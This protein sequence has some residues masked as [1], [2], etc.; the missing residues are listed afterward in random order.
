[1]ISP[2]EELRQ[3]RIGLVHAFAAGKNGS[4]FLDSHTETMDHYFRRSLQE[5][6]TGRILF[7]EK[8]PLAVVALGGYGRKELCLHSDIDVMILF[9]SKIPPQAKALTDE[10]L[11]P[12]WDIGLDLGYS[13]R[14]AKDCLRLGAEDFEVLTSLMD[15]RFL[16]G[17]SPLYLSL[18]KDLSAK[19]IRK[20][21][22]IFGRW[23]LERDAIRMETYGDASYLLEPDLKE[24]IG[25]LRDYHHILWLA[26]AFHKLL[27][28]RDLEYSGTLSHDEYRE[29]MG[30]LDFIWLVRN[31]LHHLSGRANDRLNF[32]YQERIADKLGFRDE[33]H[34]L[35]VEHF[36]GRLHASMAFI[37]SLHRSFN[38]S[39]LSTTGTARDPGP[40]ELTA[41]LVLS[42]GETHFQSATAIPSEPYILMEVFRRSADAGLSLS[43]DAKRLV[44][45]FL[46]LVDDTFRCAHR[47]IADFLEII[48][49]DHACEALDQMDETGFL[50]AFIPEIGKVRD[51]VQFDA[52]HIYPVGRHMIQTLRY[53]K[54][55]RKEKNLIL[56]DVFS[57]IQEPASLFLA[58]LLHDVGK[59]GKDHAERGAV[60]AR[61]ILR[62]LS[63]FDRS[64][65]DILF[66]IRHHLL[67]AETATRRDLDDEK[68]VVQVART[69]GSVDRLK[70]LYL[71]TWADSMATGPRAWNEWIAN[72]VQELFFKLLHILSM[73]E[74]ATPAAEE[75][76]RKT[77]AEVESRMAGKISPSELNDFFEV[78]TPR[79]ILNTEPREVA[80][81]IALAKAQKASRVAADAHPFSLEARQDESGGIWEVTFL[82][83]DRP[84]LFAD[85]TGVLALRNINILSAQI[86][87]WRDGTA[88]DVFKV[89]SP[90]DMLHPEETWEKVRKDLA[91]LFTGQMSLSELL[92]QKAS[93]SLLETPKKPCRPPTVIIDNESSDFS[94]LIEVF[95]DDRIGLLYTITNALH[96]LGLDIRIAKVA[97]KGDQIADV[98]YVR[99]LEGQKVLDEGRV[100][101]IRETLLR[102]LETRNRPE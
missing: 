35:G 26:R 81:H 15:A 34:E 52:Y 96:H 71:L 38:S 1:V 89:T 41:A 84:G 68:I 53:L 73:G 99:N 67:L 102:E 55:L 2:I 92:A 61:G 49:G 95:A 22:P 19:V 10:L 39:H 17:D 58:G 27:A 88:V 65:E 54:G 90:L 62:R 86:Y 29:M 79:Y 63:Y 78:M 69:I 42:R 70:M 59:T 37:K 60:I 5:S 32:E 93:P 30:H 48:R 28:P 50:E 64:A 97:T 85:F 80:R 44:K 66:L 91:E 74:L 6:L 51:R 75:K 25:G 16:C 46:Y 9:G 82:A 23:L 14:T 24:G 13:V 83:K 47:P 21:A 7:R 12:M 4:G 18:M 45:E 43:L 72:L 40:K 3:A 20:K 98:F 94:T 11:L 8:R 36:L 31:H 56:L 76:T 33:K 100:D 57:D 101:E 87:T 77:R